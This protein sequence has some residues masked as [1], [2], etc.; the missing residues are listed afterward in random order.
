MPPL[1]VP[2]E[3]IPE[4]QLQYRI[5]TMQ[6]KSQRIMAK[7]VSLKKGRS[8]YLPYLP[9]LQQ[10]LCKIITMELQKQLPSLLLQI[11]LKN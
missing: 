1:H 5:V 6:I 11:I 3:Y 2:F 9:Q 4:G 8:S 7:M 10:I